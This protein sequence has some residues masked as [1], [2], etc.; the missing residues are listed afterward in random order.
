MREV[1][2][3]GEEHSYSCRICRR[4]YFFIADA[5]TWLNN[6]GYSPI[7]QDL[8]TIS[9]WEEGIAGS[10]AAPCSLSRTINGKTC[11]V[12]AIYLTHSDSDCSTILSQ[13][14]GVA[15][16]GAHCTPRKLQIC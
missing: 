13:Q 6:S 7:D 5:S 8:Q 3:S 9:K 14:D 1:S 15:L 10:N 11:R 4:D 12:N 16:N 2:C